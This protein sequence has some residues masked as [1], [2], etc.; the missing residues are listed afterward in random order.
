MKFCC[1]GGKLP[2]SVAGRILQ[3]LGSDGKYENNS[4]VTGLYTST[5]DTQLVPC[6]ATDT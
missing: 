6:T 5:E 2:L 1:H 3:K 4:D